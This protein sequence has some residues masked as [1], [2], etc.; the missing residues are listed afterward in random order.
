ML[1]PF[2][3]WPEERVELFRLPGRPGHDLGRAGMVDSWIEPGATRDFRLKVDAPEMP[4]LYLLQIDMVDEGV[5]WFSDLGT[6]GIVLEITVVETSSADTV[7]ADDGPS[8]P[9]G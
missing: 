8:P 6:P 3:S 2:D 1:G 4:G 5:H 9:G 7:D